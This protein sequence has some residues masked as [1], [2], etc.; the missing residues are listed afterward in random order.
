MLYYAWNLLFVKI[1]WH[2]NPLKSIC[3]LSMRKYQMHKV[4]VLENSD[5]QIPDF[6]K[7]P[8]FAKHKQQQIQLKR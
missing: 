6:E 5:N 2:S 8:V 4:D 3:K 7:N 1:P